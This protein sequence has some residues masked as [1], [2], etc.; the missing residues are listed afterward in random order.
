MVEVYGQMRSRREFLSFLGLGSIAT[1]FGIGV[2]AS[3]PVRVEQIA[4]PATDP[5][6]GGDWP[7]GTRFLRPQGS[8]IPEGW[9]LSG[10]SGTYA[11][12]IT[13]VGVDK[14]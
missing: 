9:E 3:A 5:S 12:G 14:L 6:Y 13:Y 8:P 7:S 2:L 11:D 1:A 4:A 10:Y